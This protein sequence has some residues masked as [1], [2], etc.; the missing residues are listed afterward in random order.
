[1]PDTTCPHI[2]PIGT[3]CKLGTNL[4]CPAQPGRVGCPFPGVG[5]LDQ[6]ASSRLT[7][8][9]PEQ[10][11][12][13]TTFATLAEPFP[14]LE[15]D[16]PVCAHTEDRAR[17]LVEP[18]LQPRAILDR[19][20]AIV[21]PG[22]WEDHYDID[23]PNRQAQCR[24][25]I[26]GVTKEDASDSSI[27]VR[28]AVDDAL[29]R[30]AAKFGIGRYLE[31]LEA[32]WVDADARSGQ[33]LVLPD[34][35][36]WA[37]PISDRAAARRAS[38]QLRPPALE[39]APARAASAGRAGSRPTTVTH[40]PGV[41]GPDGLTDRLISELLKT[42]DRLPGGAVAARAVLTDKNWTAQ[43]LAARRQLYGELQLVCRQIRER[44]RR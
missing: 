12:V 13:Q 41:K 4:R 1:M 10:T 36:E 40:D 20:D 32:T 26:L 11:P 17:V 42:L 38:S 5:S 6:R 33:P 15:L 37:I 35:P 9:P 2:T 21:G 27:N 29:R 28:E 8:R 3:W 22:A 16:W 19:L 31:R 23:T 44:A 24:L 34:L 43:P 25:T 14:A 7:V 18:R 30:A 39:G